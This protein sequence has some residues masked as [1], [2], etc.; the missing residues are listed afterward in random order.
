MTQ[1]ENNQDTCQAMA[2]EEKIQQKVDTGG[3]R[4]KKVYFGG[5]EHFRNWRQQYI[6]VYGEENILIEEA[7]ARSLPCY[8]ESGEK[9]FRIWVPDKD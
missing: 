2:D 9:A 4:W 7:D 8:A 1:Q 5:G 6:E 3:R